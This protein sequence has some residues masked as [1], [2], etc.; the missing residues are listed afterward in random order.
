WVG[1]PTSLGGRTL[2]LKPTHP[3]GPAPIPGVDPEGRGTVK[4]S[5][6]SPNLNLCDRFLFRKLKHLLQ[7]SE[8][9]G[10]EE[11]TLAVQRAMRR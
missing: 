7:E 4:Q 9:G 11:A 6:Y 1:G 2:P 5:P 3:A 10:H 8:F